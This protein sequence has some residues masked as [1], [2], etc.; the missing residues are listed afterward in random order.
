MKSRGDDRL[1]GEAEVG[2]LDVVCGG[3]EKNKIPRERWH[4]EVFGVL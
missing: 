4:D 2:R 3:A 1:K